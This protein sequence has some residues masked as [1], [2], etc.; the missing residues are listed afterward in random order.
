M[1]QPKEQSPSL[2]DLPAPSE[3][4]DRLEVQ[5]STSYVDA[6]LFHYGRD[7]NVLLPNQQVSALATAAQFEGQWAAGQGTTGL[8]YCTY[9]FVVDS[10]DRIPEIHY[11]WDVPPADP[12]LVYFGLANWAADHWDWYRGLPESVAGMI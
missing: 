9:S 5:R 7:F 11:G 4:A 10:Y 3:L 6:D 2:P 8:P 12:T 1:G